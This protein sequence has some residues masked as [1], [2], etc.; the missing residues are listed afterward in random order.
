[1][2][3][4]SVAKNLI[5]LESRHARQGLHDCAHCLS[6]SLCFATALDTDE[7][8]ELDAQIT[9]LRPTQRKQSLCRAGDAFGGL[10]IVRS[11][12]F[13][14]YRLHEDGTMH[15]TGFHLAGEIM[16]MGDTSTGMRNDYIEALETSSVCALSLASLEELMAS[17]P[18]LMMQILA[19]VFAEVESEK[20][21]MYLLGKQDADQK[22]ASFLLSLV[23]RS[24]RS[25]FSSNL[26]S[27]SMMRSDIANYLAMAV[28]TISR[29][30]RRFVEQG[31]LTTAYREIEILDH[32]ALVKLAGGLSHSVA[33]RAPT[34]QIVF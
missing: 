17:S 24:A 34:S 22:L 8:S 33:K 27:L 12:S 31:L 18:R 5:H 2:N 16:G 29:V 26:L 1:M 7:I 19:K 21:R 11:G 15:I 28:E 14:S 4:I 13:K 32:S 3:S 25:G 30:L 6:R 9:N 10:Y 20:D 23:D